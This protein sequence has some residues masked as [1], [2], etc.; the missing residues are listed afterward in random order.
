[1]Y[2]CRESRGTSHLNARCGRV[3]ERRA[4]NIRYDAELFARSGQLRAAV[5]AKGAAR[6]RDRVLARVLRIR[7]DVAIAAMQRTE[8]QSFG[9][10]CRAK[11]F[12]VA[13]VEDEL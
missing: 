8:H 11:R 13:H 1:M 3:S 6:H 9:C 5:L 2:P 7:E 4:A 12:D 10:T